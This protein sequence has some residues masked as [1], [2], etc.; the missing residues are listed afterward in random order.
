M[1]Y[2]T[3]NEDRML[4]DQ[5]RKSIMNRMGWFQRTKQIQLGFKSLDLE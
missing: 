2:T 3:Q 5:N 4:K 1:V